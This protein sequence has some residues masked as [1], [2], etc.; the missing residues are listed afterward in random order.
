MLIIGKAAV[1]LVP[2]M[3][4]TADDFVS[5]NGVVWQI[6]VVASEW[7]ASQ[8]SGDFASVLSMEESPVIHNSFVISPFVSLCGFWSG[9][10]MH[11]QALTTIIR[12]S[13]SETQEAENSTENAKPC[14]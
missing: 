9:T 6:F 14:L 4:D 10:A 12:L 3:H 7:E 8:S 11:K 2:S 1:I 13:C 5:I